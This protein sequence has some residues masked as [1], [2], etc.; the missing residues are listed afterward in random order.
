MGSF[1]GSN[2]CELIGIH[3]HGLSRIIDKN[4]IGINKDDGLIILINV[5]RQKTDKT[6]KIVIKSLKNMVFGISLKTNCKK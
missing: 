1:D 6:R 4:G 2:I 5:N 3:L